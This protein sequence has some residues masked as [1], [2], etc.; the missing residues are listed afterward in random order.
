MFQNVTLRIQHFTEK[1]Q[2]SLQNQDTR[3]RKAVTP[4]ERLAVCLR[5]ANKNY[6]FEGNIYSEKF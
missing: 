2:N 4:Q 1:I 3:W 5:N 6:L